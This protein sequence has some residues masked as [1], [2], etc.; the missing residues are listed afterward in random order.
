MFP[1]LTLARLIANSPPTQKHARSRK[2]A[3]TKTAQQIDG[4]YTEKGYAGFI[5]QMEAAEG[6]FKRTS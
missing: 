6:I 2:L 3:Q 4:A 5:K 1:P